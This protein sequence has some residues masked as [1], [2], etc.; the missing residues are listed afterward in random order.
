MTQL[1]A[2][3]S[4]LALVAALFGLQQTA[5]CS[6]RSSSDYKAKNIPGT[7]QRINNLPP[8]GPEDTFPAAGAQLLLTDGSVLVQ[9]FNF[10]HTGE[11]WK[12]TPDEFGSYVNG[13][14]T[15]I[16]SL[17]EGY[18]PYL[19]ASAVLPDGRVIIEGGQYNGPVYDQELTSLGA[20]YDPVADSW[21]MVNPP[22]FFA[23]GV[24]GIPFLP[25][26]P[27]QSVVLEDG[28]FMLADALSLQAALLDAKTLTWKPVGHNKFDVNTNEGWTLLPNGK[29]LAVDT[30]VAGPYSDT[31]PGNSELF[32]PKTGFWSATDDTFLVPLT[33]FV[34]GTIGPQVLR[35]DGTVFVVGG[36]YT[37]NTAIYNSASAT[38]S[39]GPVL[40]F[41]GTAQVGSVP[42]VIIDPPNGAA[43][44]YS[45]KRGGQPVSQGDFN[46]SGLIVPTV[47]ANA[48]TP[49]A[50]L[51]PNSIALIAT[52][53]F[54]TNTLNKGANAVAAGAI[55]CIF[56]DSTGNDFSSNI[57]GSSEVPSVMVPYST[58]QLF[59]ANLDGLFGTM[60][61]EAADAAVGYAAQSGPGA[62]LRNGNVLF[63]VSKWGENGGEAPTKFF[64][65]DGTALYEQSAVTTAEVFPSANFGMLVLPTGQ[66]MMTDSFTLAVEIYTPG[67]SSYDKDWAPVIHKAPKKVHRGKTYKIEGVRFNGMSQGAMFGTNYQSATNYPLVRITNSE[68]GHVFYARTHDHSYMGVA[69]DKKVHTYF[70][71]PADIELGKC[72]LEVVA[73][74][75]PSK[76]YHI[77]VK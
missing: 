19:F 45:A 77:H 20:I 4:L 41:A 46:V 38:W 10:P 42:V 75:I 58:G 61:I 53:G 65:F 35:P 63:A 3:Y 5:Y 56:Y 32:N 54:G 21:T 67:D 7:W 66:I 24:T 68:T 23:N 22:E 69:S 2:I 55:G 25:I 49:V 31:L 43:G 29:V 14:W 18:S 44:T 52:D 8:F 26:G 27:A 6:S 15:Q 37:G 48:D 59:L 72:V 73:N 13:T 33:D 11:V 47:P 16:A 60:T 28:T 62:L 1:R 36:Y 64:E 50:P 40:P 71:V 30:F 74:G 12:L 34:T 17:P 9:N 51:P 57:N 70:D 76:P 39:P